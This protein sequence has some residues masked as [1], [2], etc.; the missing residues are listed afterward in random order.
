VRVPRSIRR[1]L[2]RAG[3]KRLVV[4]IC[5]AIGLAALGVSSGAAGAASSSPTK[6]GTINVAL[7]NVT[8]CLDPQVSPQ[9]QTYEIARNIVDSLVAQTSA[10]KFLP[11]LATSWVV[12]SNAEQF[13]FTLRQGVTFSDGTVFD[14][15]VVKANFDRIVN[16]ATKSQFAAGLLKNYTGT[17]VIS[18]TKVQVNFSQ[19]D[20]PFLNALSTSY[21]GIESPTSW[22]ALAACAPPVGSGPFVSASYTAQQSDTL[23]RSPVPYKWGP[24]YETNKTGSA[25]LNQINF[26]FVTEDSVRTGGLSS[27]QFQYIEGVPPTSAE[28][29]KSSGY[30]L[31]QESQPGLAYGYQINTSVAPFTDIKVRQALSYAVDAAGIDN[32]LYAGEYQQ[33]KHILSS[34]TPGVTPLASTLPYN[35]KKANSILS[36]DGWSTRNSAGVR[37]KNGQPLSFSLAS[38]DPRDQRQSMDLLVQQELQKVGFQVNLNKFPLASA[39]QIIDTGQFGIAGNAYILASPSVLVNF[40]TPA[41]GELNLSKTDVPAATA[42]LATAVATTNAAKAAPIYGQAQ[43]LIEGNYSVVPIYQL[44]RLDATAAKLHGVDLDTAKFPYF[45]DAWLS[46]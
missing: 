6:G 36:A 34:T 7:D 14:G 26:Q 39:T 4:V 43:Q 28:A 17:T 24:S 27:G 38:Y 29:T 13:T 18:P 25:Y 33:A 5:G 30:T 11:W 35:V 9:Y 8:L 16:P 42:K 21:L 1:Q 46:K 19:P 37:V 45:V 10:G 32:A 41:G 20:A 22:A 2:R 23:K 15:S 44:T 40:Y 31:I 3:R 12:S